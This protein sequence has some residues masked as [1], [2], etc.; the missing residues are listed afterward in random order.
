MMNSKNPLSEMSP[1]RQKLFFITILLTNIVVM[2]EMVFSPI[3]NNIY[4]TYPNNAFMVNTLISSTSIMMVVTSLVAPS[5]MKR[6]SKK[7]ILLIGSLLVAI[8][9]TLGV[10]MD[11]L[12]YMLVMRSLYGIGIALVNVTAIALIAEFY[13]DENKRTSVMG[14]YNAIMALIGAILAVVAGNLAAISW[15]SVFWA[16]LSTVPMIIMV[17]FFIPS[18]RP[19]Q[20]DVLQEN[21]QGLK[22]PL[23][24]NFWILLFNYTLFTIAYSALLFFTSTYVAENNL[25]TPALAGYLNSV[26]TLGSF[27][28]CLAFGWV[29][30]KLHRYTPI[31]FY[32]AAALCNVLL[33]LYPNRVLALVVCTL[34]GG[35]YGSIFSYGYAHSAAVVPSSR[36]NDAVGIVTAAYSIAAFFTTYIVTGLMGLLN[37]DKFTPIF[38]FCALLCIIA[39]GFETIHSLSTRKHYS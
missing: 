38:G 7:Y 25:G 4:E 37:T 10:A 19:D 39:A 26:G 11:S 20:E 13:V 28:F 32:I 31:P 5:L 27:T 36:I 16:Y 22:E 3:I 1:S 34:Y 9:G 23:G 6:I 15:K 24:K 21:K 17:F 30:S 29:Y 35:I 18:I 14:Y 2:G 33:L 12:S 8:C